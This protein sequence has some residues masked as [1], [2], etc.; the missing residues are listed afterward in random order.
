MSRKRPNFS[1]ETAADLLTTL[2]KHRSI[3][4]DTTACQE[5]IAERL[6][7]IGFATENIPFNSTD[8][9]HAGGA[10]DSTAGSDG[11]AAEAAKQA[12]VPINNLW[13]TYGEPPYL[14]F[15][16]H[17]DV[18][19][20]GQESLWRHPPFAATIE[21]LYIYGRGA[22]DMK[23]SIAAMLVAVRDHLA[24]MSGEPNTNSASESDTNKNPPS[25]LDEPNTNL[26]SKSDTNK[27]PPSMPDASRAPGGIAFLITADEEGEAIDGVEAA[28][29][30][31]AKRQVAISQCLVGE[32]TC[33]QNLGDTIKIGR[34]GSLRLKL[35]L[36]G[37]QGHAAYLASGDNL[38]HR[39]VGFLNLM[40]AE[41]WDKD[42]TT[43]PPG[44]SF[45]VINL[46]TQSAADN[47]TAQGVSLQCNWRYDPQLH[48]HLDELKSKVGDLLKSAGF[49]LDASDQDTPAD[50]FAARCE[51]STSAQPYFCE[52]A[53]LA[54]N[55]AQAIQDTIG[56]QADFTT[57]GGTSDGRFF[58][59]YGVEVAE[60]GPRN[61][62][63]HCV[64][65]RLAIA[66]L[67]QLTDI[68]R[69]FLQLHLNP[70]LAP[71]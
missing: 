33:E 14:V 56:V 58:P 26:A 17:T 23:G 15:C 41:N 25:M 16:G 27:N 10:D 40:L 46:T 65:E 12:I 42:L 44:T 61:A 60:F 57:S 29:K 47:V 55:L 59:A 70:H 2:I 67:N 45:N 24:P 69:R 7:E 32:P 5:Q 22:A 4:P 1:T 68:Y 52:K 34:R 9:P 54:G 6:R 63:I 8:Y 38:L 36:Q 66:E 19:P 53:T 13:A 71:K 11:E 50:S 43:T 49:T 51:W 37:A 62:T 3:T 31:L 64:D 21:N 20:P 48:N 39:A 35:K 18:V 28:L 30:E